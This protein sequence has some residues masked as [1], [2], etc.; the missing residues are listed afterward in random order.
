M[1]SGVSASLNERLEQLNEE[2]QNELKSKYN[3]L[4]STGKTNE[5]AIA[6]LEAAEAESK[7][8][9]KFIKLTD[10]MEA[11][12]AAV[13]DNKTPVVIDCSADSK[14]DTFYSYRS[15]IVLDGKKMGIQ[16]SIEKLPVCQIMEESRQKLVA[17]IKAGCPLVISMQRSVTDFAET[18]TDEAQVKA[19]NT[20][21][22]DFGGDTGSKAKK[23]LPAEMFHKAGKSLLAEDC[24]NALFRD[25]E[26]E[27]GIAFC[28]NPDEFHVILTTSFDPA[29]AEGYL[30]EQEWGLPKPSSMY[31]FIAIEHDPDVPLLD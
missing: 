24:L 13:A 10:L 27:A 2:Q 20:E 4:L 16:K 29:D 21:S 25:Q 12:Q 19:G 6:L 3:D 17:A 5:E 14:V 1:G 8:E 31:Q 28:R 30:L 26:K 9:I 15:V 22:I 7:Q 18:F 11:V 23:Y